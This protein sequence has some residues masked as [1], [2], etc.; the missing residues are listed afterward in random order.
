M[1]LATVLP[2]TP[3]GFCVQTTVISAGTS[4]GNFELAEIARDGG[5]VVSIVPLPE[6]ANAIKWEAKALVV[7]FSLL[8]PEAEID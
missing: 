6:P 1:E 4:V 5:R 2:E 3:N 8:K 7:Y